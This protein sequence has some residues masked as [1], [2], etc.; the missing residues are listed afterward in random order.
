VGAKGMD[1]EYNYKSTKYRLSGEGREDVSAGKV[2]KLK[3]CTT[4]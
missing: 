2:I 3:V 1:E 4:F